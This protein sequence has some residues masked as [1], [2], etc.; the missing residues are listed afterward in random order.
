MLNHC[1]DLWKIKGLTEGESH[2]GL[3]LAIHA[4]KDGYCFPGV[5]KLAEEA[6]MNERTVR[7]HLVALERLSLIVKVKRPNPKKGE[8]TGYEIHYADFDGQDVRFLTSYA[9]GRKSRT[10]RKQ[11]EQTTLTT[12]TDDL[13]D[14]GGVGKPEG[15]G[16]L[17]TGGSAQGPGRQGS[18]E[19]AVRG[20]PGGDSDGFLA[21][22]GEK[23]LPRSDSRADGLPT[24]TAP[25]PAPA[26]VGVDAPA[27]EAV[28][29][30]KAAR[31]W[32]PPRPPIQFTEMPPW[33]EDRQFWAQMSYKQLAQYFKHYNYQV[34][35]HYAVFY[36]RLY[37]EAREKGWI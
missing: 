8:T 3:L 26:L 36:T 21:A 1:H 6:R 20:A 10:Q 28:G 9:K 13:G 17:L 5:R 14:L 32:R 37:F 29:A 27:P 4:D 11:E 34:E 12:Q 25:A 19:R 2:I 7:Y 22:D 15:P 35:G 23:V 18:P 31:E 30:S 33:V 24:P 16:V